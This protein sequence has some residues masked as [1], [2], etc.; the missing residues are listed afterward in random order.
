MNYLISDDRRTLTVFVDLGE[1]A[2]LYQ[3]HNEIGQDRHLHDAFERLI[4]NSELE[5]I[6]PEVCGDL[7]DAPILG[8][9]G[10]DKWVASHRDGDGTILVGSD[11]RRPVNPV[12]V[13]E[14][15]ERW[16]FMGYEL[17]SPLHD[18]RDTGRAVF[19][20]P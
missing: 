4:A 12:N 19:V 7:T 3:L 8:I 6:A 20:A 11:A 17:R 1:R 2:A 14:I 13:C 18:L 9:W 5:W 16:A 15:V 10:P